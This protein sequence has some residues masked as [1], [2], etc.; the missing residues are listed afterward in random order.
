VEVEAEEVAEDAGVGQKNY[1]E[2]G[3]RG[4]AADFL[5]GE[6]MEGDPSG[7]EEVE[8]AAIKINDNCTHDGAISHCLTH[9][10][11]HKARRCGPRQQD[12]PLLPKTPPDTPC[13]YDRIGGVYSRF[14]LRVLPPKE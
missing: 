11:L 4:S 13:T 7:R 9:H 6:E 8:A 12:S 14:C 3:P 10:V 1:E 5:L 2:P